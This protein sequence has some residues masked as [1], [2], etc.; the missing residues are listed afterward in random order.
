[1]GQ[2]ICGV[3]HAAWETIGLEDELRKQEKKLEA[4]KEEESQKRLM[5]KE[6]DLVVDMAWEVNFNYLI[7]AWPT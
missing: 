1:V 3:L 4:N 2:V 5:R 7:D 6:L